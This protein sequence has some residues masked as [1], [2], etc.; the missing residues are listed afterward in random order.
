MREA[1]EAASMKLDEAPIESLES[2][3]MFERYHAPLRLAY[4]RIQMD[5]DRH[6]SDQECLELAVFAINCT[7]EPACLCPILLV[8]RAVPRPERT[9]PAPRQLERA[10][11]VE[12]LVK[13]I[14]KEQARR[15]IVFGVR[16]RKAPKEKGIIESNTKVTC[17]CP[18]LSVSNE[19]QKLNGTIQ[20]Y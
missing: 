15:G 13:V 12:D 8:Y 5:C 18:R 6:V 17:R 10:R 11:L 14:E 2:I 3:G 16:P 20:T 9:T 19:N 7:V 4:S 1:A